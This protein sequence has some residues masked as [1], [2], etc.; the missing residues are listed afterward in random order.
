[1]EQLPAHH[2][3]KQTNKLRIQ[4]FSVSFKADSV[5]LFVVD[6]VYFPEVSPFFF[7][8]LCKIIGIKVKW[9]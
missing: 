8:Y 4:L 6:L 3:N 5:T 9:G 7:E 2:F 1:M